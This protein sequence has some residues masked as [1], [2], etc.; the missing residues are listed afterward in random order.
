MSA[1]NTL[2]RQQLLL[3]AAAACGLFVLTLFVPWLGVNSAEISGE[4]ALPSYWLFLLM[5]VG[6][7][8]LLASESLGFDMPDWFRTA[9]HGALLAAGPFLITLAIFLEDSG[10]DRRLGI[11]AALVF[12]TLAVA[13]PLIAWR[14]E[15]LTSQRDA[16]RR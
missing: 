4:Q 15:R 1:I 9:P 2:S 14:A 8:V 12:A 5:A 6:A 3:G 13:F 11:F 7:G 16:A 10:L